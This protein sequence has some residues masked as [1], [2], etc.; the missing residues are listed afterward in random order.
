VNDQSP[1]SDDL[2]APF[3]AILQLLREVCGGDLE[4]IIIMLVVA[5]RTVRHPAVKAMS[6][7]ERM[8]SGLE[9]LPNIGVNARSIADSTGVPRETVRRKVAD[10]VAT[11]WIATTGRNLQFTTKGYRELTPGRQAL[12]RLA[13][14]FA[15]SVERRRAETVK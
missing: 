5:D 10:L 11:G 1:L 14:Q 8:E 2:V 15:A 12:E 13:E 7:A 9:F 4:K 3:L 6:T